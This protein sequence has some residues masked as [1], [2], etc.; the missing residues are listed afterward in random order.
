[1][2]RLSGSRR[3]WLLE[4][5]LPW[6]CANATPLPP[7]PQAATAESIPKQRFSGRRAT[8]LRASIAA[9]AIELAQL[10]PRTPYP[11]ALRAE[12]TRLLSWS[13]AL[14][15]A[16][17]RRAIERTLVGVLRNRQVTLDRLTIDPHGNMVAEGAGAMAAP[18]L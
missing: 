16:R 3:G 5:A 14:A 6:F 4:G 15:L 18:R 7:E 13:A 1:A 12:R 8:D 9:R 17:Q 2:A 11:G 10:V